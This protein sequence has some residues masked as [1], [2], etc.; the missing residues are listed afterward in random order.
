MNRTTKRPRTNLAG[1]PLALPRLLETLSADQMR[2]VLQEICSRHPAIGTEIMITAPR[3]SVQSAIGV[4]Q[5]YQSILNESFPYGDRPSS[6]YAYNRVRHSLVNL[7]EALRDYTP[8]F[9][10]PN[11]QSTSIS[12]EYLDDATAI[13][14]QLPSWDSYLHN[15]HKQESYEEITKAWIH[16]IREGAKKGG[17]IQLQLGKWDQKLIKHND[18]SGGKLQDALNELRTNLGW[19]GGDGLGSAQSLTASSVR[20]ELQSG[21]Y[22]ANVPVQL[23]W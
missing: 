12:L 21:M 9:L 1:R 10:P 16:V 20:Q 11:E 5:S 13:I 3:P 23:S 19:I 15:R 6:E 22:G 18:I 17:G 7:I 8:H 4:L 14:H 2:S